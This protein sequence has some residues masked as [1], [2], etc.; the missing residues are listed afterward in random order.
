MK[1]KIQKIKAIFG[2]IINNTLI[3]E[4]TKILFCKRSLAL[5]VRFPVVEPAHPG[6]SPILGMDVC[7]Y[8][9]LFQD[10]PVL[11]FSVVS[12][13]PVNNEA[14]VVTSSSSRSAGQ[15]FRGAHRGRVCMRS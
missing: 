9:D 15:S 14:P 13:V 1:K 2:F 8:L 5:M 10:Y 3:V 4:F 6:S 11:F 7:I 12:D